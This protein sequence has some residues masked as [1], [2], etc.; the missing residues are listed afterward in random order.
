[1]RTLAITMVFVLLNGLGF[2]YRTV[3]KP[4]DAT[5]VQA[6]PAPAATVIPVPPA[7]HAPA[8]LAVEPAQVA[9][10]APTTVAPQ[11][12]P[13]PASSELPAT[14]LRGAPAATPA[15][16]RRGAPGRLPGGRSRVAAP[17]QP[18]PAPAPASP[19]SAEGSAKNSDLLQKMEANPY[20][21]G[22]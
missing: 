8:A 4:H 5:P 7:A 17:A 16:A 9:G 21:R 13:P 6:A 2:L 19:E 22:E 18:A 14:A 3:M 11:P 20:K 1:M 12:L 10:S 15:P